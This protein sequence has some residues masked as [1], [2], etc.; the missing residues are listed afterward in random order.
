M[1]DVSLIPK[2]APKSF[3]INKLF[4]WI[5][6]LVLIISVVAGGLIVFMLISSKNNLVQLNQQL[7][8]LDKNINSQQ[9][10]IQFAQSVLVADQIISSHKYPSRLMDFLEK[11]TNMFI[12]WTSLN[13]DLSNKTVDLNVRAHDILAVAQQIKS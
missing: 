4:S 1:I 8:E 11:N 6:L 13:V 9:E 10:T 2:E 3:P 7:Q 12:Q 5:S